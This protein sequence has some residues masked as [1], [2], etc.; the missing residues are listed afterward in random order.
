[1]VTIQ[2]PAYYSLVITNNQEIP[3][4]LKNQEYHYKLNMQ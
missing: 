2:L 1:M 3:M 4:L